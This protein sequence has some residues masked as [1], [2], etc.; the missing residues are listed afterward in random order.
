MCGAVDQRRAVSVPGIRSQRGKNVEFFFTFRR[1]E[2]RKSQRAAAETL[3]CPL[4][5]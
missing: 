1:L 5:A 4:G 3:N 2:K